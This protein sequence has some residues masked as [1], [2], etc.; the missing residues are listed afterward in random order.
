MTPSDTGLYGQSDNG[1]CRQKNL[2]C[3]ALSTSAS[4]C[5]PLVENGNET[6]E[7]E[8]VELPKNNDLHRLPKLSLAWLPVKVWYSRRIAG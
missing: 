7:G 3:F 4:Q 2:K 6:Q 1:L 8:L 5:F